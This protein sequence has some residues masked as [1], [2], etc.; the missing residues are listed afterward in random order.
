MNNQRH[1]FTQKFYHKIFILE[2]N[3]KRFLPRKFRAIWYAK[4]ISVCLWILAR[5]I[6]ADNSRF[7]KFAKSFPH[8]CM[9]VSLSQCRLL[10]HQIC[11]TIIWSNTQLQ[12][13][14]QSIAQQSPV[15]NSLNLKWNRPNN[16]VTVIVDFQKIYIQVKLSSK[17]LAT[18]Y[19][20]AESF[21][22]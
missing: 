19:C 9:V 18:I 15:I 4:Y 14:L 12:R 10:H 17:W 22:G 20:I 11:V 7:A 6:L 3:H 21:W 1:N 16:F 5:K 13:E 2:R 8:L